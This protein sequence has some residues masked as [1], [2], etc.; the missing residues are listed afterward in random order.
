MG[1]ASGERTQ[2]FAT[3]V[4][5]AKGMAVG[6]LGIVLTLD[7]PVQEFVE[8]VSLSDDARRERFHLSPACTPIVSAVKAAG[9]DP[10]RVRVFV[11][12]NIG[13]TAASSP[14]EPS[15]WTGK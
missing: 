14:I 6:I 2:R 11:D 1:P 5:V 8:L 9:S 3:V 13:T 4:R 12:C 7:A 15:S 10:T